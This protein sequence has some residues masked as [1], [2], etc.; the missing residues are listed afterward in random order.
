MWVE[1]NPK[2]FAYRVPIGDYNYLQCD[3]SRVSQGF[4]D[5]YRGTVSDF[6]PTFPIFSSKY[7]VVT[8]KFDNCESNCR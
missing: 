6:T 5:K 4:Y 8:C 2:A 3:V 7:D 1:K